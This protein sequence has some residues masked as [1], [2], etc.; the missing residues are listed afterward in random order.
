MKKKV[1]I[2]VLEII[3]IFLVAA[4][5]ILICTGKFNFEVSNTVDDEII[6]LV[7]NDY[8]ASNI[9]YGTPKTKEAYFIDDE[10]QYIG[11][12]YDDYK[13]LNYPYSLIDNTY[14]GLT[15]TYFEEDVNKYNQYIE[16][17]GDI[18]VSV[19]SKCDV[20]KYDKNISTYIDKD[21]NTMV[22]SNGREAK[23]VKEKGKYKLDGSL[24]N[25]VE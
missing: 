22:K 14:T 8:K 19:N 13:S 9:L 1:L 3:G 12:D 18:Y 7:K 5:I 2:L 17:N 10:V 24:Y 21:N 23:V 6:K 16:Y 25:C 11:I 15:H 4:G 20:S